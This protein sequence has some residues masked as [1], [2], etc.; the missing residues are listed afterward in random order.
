ANFSFDPAKHPN[1]DVQLD[2]AVFGQIHLIEAD[3]PHI[4]EVKI[5]LRIRASLD[6]ILMAIRPQLNLIPHEEEGHLAK[7][8]LD[9]SSLSKTTRHYVRNRKCA[10][11]D[12]EIV[13]PMQSLSLH[14]RPELARQEQRRLDSFTDTTSGSDEG[15]GKD[16][17]EDGGKQRDEKREE[18][19]GIPEH[20]TVDSLLIN[21]NNARI[22]VQLPTVTIQRRLSLRSEQGIEIISAASAQRT[23]LE[24][25]QGSIS[26][27]LATLNTVRA[28]VVGEGSIA[29]DIDGND[30]RVKDDGLPPAQSLD[31]NAK[32]AGGGN[33][34]VRVFTPYAF[35]GRFDLR[36]NGKVELRRSTRE[37]A[38]EVTHESKN[39][40]AGYLA[41]YGKEPSSLLP[42]IA[43][44]AVNTG[45]VSLQLIHKDK[46]PPLPDASSSITYNPLAFLL[47]ALMSGLFI[48][49]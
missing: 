23:E 41:N 15:N 37:M 42:N 10:R 5:N 7:F 43:L 1:L 14:R 13:Y 48:L 32:T 46:E 36:H 38:L 49:Q 45:N 8:S 25:Q 35:Q 39:R 4:R 21:A 27:R 26:A 16:G 47:V 18:P 2:N 44:H 40:L 9:L 33:I 29:L 22:I 11:V 31:V 17:E 34:E 6:D 30:K 20:S 12:T 28:M 3:D 24:V 19:E